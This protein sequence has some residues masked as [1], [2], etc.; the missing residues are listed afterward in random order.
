MG[1]AKI[2]EL[3]IKQF[4]IVGIFSTVKTIKSIAQVLT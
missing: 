2:I 3:I 4:G 1:K